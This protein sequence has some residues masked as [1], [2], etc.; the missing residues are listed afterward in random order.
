MPGVVECHNIGT[1]LTEIAE[2]H[3]SFS[4]MLNN[5]TVHRLEQAISFERVVRHSEVMG[6]GAEARER[7]PAFLTGDRVVKAESSRQARDRG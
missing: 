4:R 2:E 7:Q 3:I 5:V 1:A 6:Y